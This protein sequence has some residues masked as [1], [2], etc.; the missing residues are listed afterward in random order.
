[1]SHDSKAV[2][3]AWYVVNQLSPCYLAL[4]DFGLL[5]APTPESFLTSRNETNDTYLM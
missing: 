1:M 2:V 5:R 4:V 3:S